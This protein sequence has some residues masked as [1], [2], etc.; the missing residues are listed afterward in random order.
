L[1]TEIDPQKL[2]KDKGKRQTTNRSS[3]EKRNDTALDLL[4]RDEF[5]VEANTF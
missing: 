5:V 2:G 1:V 3:D 4:L